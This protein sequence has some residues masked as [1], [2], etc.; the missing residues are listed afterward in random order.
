MPLCATRNLLAGDWS[1]QDV[2][3]DA[4]T[5]EGDKT[6]QKRKTTD[7]QFTVRYSHIADPTLMFYVNPMG[8]SSKIHS[9]IRPCVSN[10]PNFLLKAPSIF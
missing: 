9:L 7:P 10:E 5:L 4:H 1:T 3:S 6:N 8:D 2:I